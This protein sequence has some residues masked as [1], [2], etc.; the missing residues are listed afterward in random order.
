MQDLDIKV[1][2]NLFNLYNTYV[3]IG[4]MMKAESADLFVQLQK[5]SQEQQSKADLDIATPLPLCKILFER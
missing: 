1:N 3:F 2:T 5:S 4:F